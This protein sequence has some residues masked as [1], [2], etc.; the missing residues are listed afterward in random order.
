MIPEPIPGFSEPF[1]SL[2]HL[3]TAGAAFVGLFFLW[4]KG[5][6]NS[7]RLFALLVFS[8][9]LIFLFS[10]SGVYHLLDPAY[11]PRAVLQR[12]D[13][14][15]IWTL[16]AGT[17]TPI[18]MILFR[19]HWRW[20]VLFLVWAIAITGLV[21]EVVFFTSV[22]GW[23]SL[24]FYLGLGWLGVLTSWHFRRTFDDKSI[25]YLWLGGLHYSIG[26]VF[27]FIQFPILWP[28]V[29]GPHEIFHIFVILGAWYHWR[30]IYTWA[31]YPT[32]SHLTFEIRVFP[33]GKHIAS[34]VGE[35]INVT[36]DSQ[37]KIRLLIHE[38]VNGL[39][40]PKL[41]PETIRLKYFQEELL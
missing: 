35:N 32:R 38:K 11:T 18:H 25:R 8:L 16:I 20:T 31:Y 34:A 7:T 28:G 13:H 41:K 39:F 23:M 15:G 27:D 24:S 10:M 14:A 26:A 2:S 19:G 3:L 5:W 4:I 30:F 36:A 21:L 22:P 29:I 33:D 40:H 1:S 6:G 12:L 17:F 37:E 9:S